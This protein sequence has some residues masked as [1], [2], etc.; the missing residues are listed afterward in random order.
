MKHKLFEY[1]LCAV[2]ILFLDGCGGLDAQRTRA[3]ATRPSDATANDSDTGRARASSSDRSSK[4][5][6]EELLYIE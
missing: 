4:Q 2:A 5:K 1:S 6:N 3:A